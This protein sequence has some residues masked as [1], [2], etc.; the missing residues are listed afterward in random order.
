MLFHRT[1][2][3]LSI[4]TLLIQAQVLSAPLPVVAV[5][6]SPPVVP[7]SAE[8]LSTARK[9]YGQLPVSFEP[10]VG[11]APAAVRFLARTG[12]Y[13]V[14]LLP[15]E[16]LFA[17]QSATPGLTK[18]KGA[19]QPS[20]LSTKTKTALVQMQLVGADSQAQLEGIDALPGKVNYLKGNDPSQW[21]T[22]VATY[23][24]VKSKS[25][26]PG[27]DLIYHSEYGQL[28]YDFVVAPHADPGRIR[29]RFSG[30]KRV[31]IDKQGGLVVESEAGQMRQLPPT[32]YEYDSG[33][34]RQLQ[35]RY[36]QLNHQTVGFSVVGHNQSRKLVIDPV[37]AYSSYL[38]GGSFESSYGVAVDEAGNAYVS[39]YTFSADFPTTSDAPQTQSSGDYEAF[40]AKLNATGTALVYSTY[41]GGGGSDLSYGVAVD[42]AG[43]A[44]VSGLT[45]STNFPTTTGALQTQLRGP[46]DVFITKVNAAGTALVY[47]TY[48]GGSDYDYSYGI[49]I[50]TT[51]NAYLTGNTSSPDFPT[52]SDAAKTQLSG[53]GDAFVTKL[54]ATGT[55]LTYST[56]LGGK[57]IDIGNSIAVD[58]AGNAY[59]TG[60]TYSTDFPTTSDA[61]QSQFGG[62]DYDAFVAKLSAAGTA[63]V[64]STYLGGKGRDEGFGIAV[65]R[66]ASAGGLSQSGSL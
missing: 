44:Y 42:R 11:Q 21:R 33:N 55:T 58:R 38:G 12:G 66:T 24:R 50:D 31:F 45:Q 22:D 16:M 7:S 43:N 36:V 32:V 65:D 51:G 63:L 18:D 62:G 8:R 30:A 61:P 28:E 29:L 19:L 25:V 59:V 39:G 49:A 4:A 52:T 17:F 57:D 34:K 54:N 10:N 40:V 23:G 46:E 15:T 53:A 6:S 37:L 1:A 5:K 14:A 13:R 41:L 27:I 20:H 9:Q 64:Y 48:L 60:L 26:Y 2:A 35:G 3:L 56:F 47:S